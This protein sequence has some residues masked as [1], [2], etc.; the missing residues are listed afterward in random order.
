MENAKRVILIFHT[1]ALGD[2][3]L[4]LFVA[5][6][7]QRLYGDHEVIYVTHASKGQLA[8]G[9]LGT[10]MSDIEG[11]RWHTLHSQAP[12][13]H[14]AAQKLLNRADRA[15]CFVAGADDLFAENLRRLSRGIQVHCVAPIPPEEWGEHVTQYYIEQLAGCLSRAELEM[16]LRE[17]RETGLR[18]PVGGARVILHIGAGALRK[19]WPVESF[20]KLAGDLRSAG[21]EV[22]AMLGEAE[23]ERLPA[24]VLEQLRAEFEVI[25]PRNYLELMEELAKARL[26]VTSD[27]GPGHLAG[28]LG[29][30]VLSL[31]GPTRAEVWRPIGPRAQVLQ[32]EDMQSIPVERVMEKIEAMLTS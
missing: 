17:L 29:V 12:A 16:A 14:P 24:G 28:V 4:T 27:N 5:R 6:T 32:G 25:C 21:H 11:F 26:L 15:V 3:V 30:K 22:A 7:L 1:G 19:C 9:L 8:A 31:F 2:L 23:L 18:E 20:L 10:G 13:L